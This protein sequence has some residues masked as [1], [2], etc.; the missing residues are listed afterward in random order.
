[1]KEAEGSEGAAYGTA[2]SPLPDEQRIEYMKS[3]S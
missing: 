1:M 3:F 2:L